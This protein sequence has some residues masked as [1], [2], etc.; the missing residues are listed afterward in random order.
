M[1]CCSKVQIFHA[2]RKCSFKQTRLLWWPELVKTVKCESKVK[3]IKKFSSSE[4]KA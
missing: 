2:S 1:H 3:K 4:L